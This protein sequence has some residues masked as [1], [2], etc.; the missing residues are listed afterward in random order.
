MAKIIIDTEDDKKSEI[1]SF[2]AANHY[3]SMRQFVLIAIDEKME[4]DK[5]E[6]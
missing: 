2:A 1:K 3:K 6:K 4:R 5:E